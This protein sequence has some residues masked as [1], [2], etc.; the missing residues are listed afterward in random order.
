MQLTSLHTGVPK[1]PFKSGL[2]LLGI[3]ATHLTMSCHTI[4]KVQTLHLRISRS[5]TPTPPS[6]M[7]PRPLMILWKGHSRSRIPIGPLHLILG[8]KKVYQPLV[9]NPM[10]VSTVAAFL[11]PCGQ[12]QLS[13]RRAKFAL[14]HK[15]PSSTRTYRIPSYRCTRGRWRNGFCS[16]GEERQ[17]AS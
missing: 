16:T 8:V 4:R 10:M 6:I 2:I 1:N 7:T 15:P 3:I 5:A 13:I 12:P 9:S 14:H 17:W 11:D